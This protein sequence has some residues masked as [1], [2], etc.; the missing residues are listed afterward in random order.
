MNKNSLAAIA[1]EKKAWRKKMNLM[2][3]TV[4][5]QK[6]QG[7][8]AAVHVLE[9]DVFK[10]A[11][12]IACYYSMA[13]EIDTLPLL[14]AILAQNKV[15]CLPKSY[16][17]G[18]LRFFRTDDLSVLQKG[19]MGIMEPKGMEEEWAGG[20]I[21]LCLVPAVAV[22]LAGRRL[23]HG[24]GYYDRFL[25]HLKGE[26]AAFV[27]KEQITQGFPCENNDFL[28]KYIIDSEGIKKA[29]K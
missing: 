6:K 5:D 21:D 14:K 3:K 11:Q 9:W 7:E 25:P 28:I 17:K 15:L 23:G 18:E 29:S 1:D 22:D 8:K 2:I 12:V 24:G 16:P 4:S 27:L 26:S 10:K 13:G 19:Y 20:E